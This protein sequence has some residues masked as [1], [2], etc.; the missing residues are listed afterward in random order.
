MPS[1]GVTE[2]RGWS[3]ATDEFWTG[4]E[5]GQGRETNVRARNVFAV[6]DSDEWDDKDHGAGPFD[7]TLIGPTYSVPADGTFTA[8]YVTDYRV[9]G[10]Q[11]GD[12]HVSWDGGE[13]QLLTSYRSDVN[14]AERLKVSAPAGADTFRLRFRY[15]GTN[16]AFWTVDRVEIQ[17]AG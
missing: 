2:W 16:S 4:A 1:G 6:A 9:D 17:D 13:P 5:P 15:T 12:V 8:A 7:S 11:T 10:P 14:R 3:F